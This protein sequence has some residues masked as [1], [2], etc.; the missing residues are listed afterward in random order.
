LQTDFIHVLFKRKPAKKYLDLL[1]RE[2]SGNIHFHFFDEPYDP[3]EISILVSG[4]SDR[5]ELEKLTNL[6]HLIFTW[7]G[8]PDKLKA[9]MPDFPDISI[10]NLHH[11]AVPVAE[12]T[13]ALLLIAAKFIIPPHN[14]L[15]KNDWRPRYQA[16]HSQLLHGKKP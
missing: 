5:E 12:N 15:A 1:K 2:I 11:N 8:L 10:H 14:A 9:Y 4:R 16:N 3:Q 6:K 13:L 7:A